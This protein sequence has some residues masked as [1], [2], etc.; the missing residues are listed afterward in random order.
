[1][2][3][4]TNSTAAAS[5]SSTVK[6]DQSSPGTTNLVQN[7]AMPD[8][9]NTFCPSADDSAAYE[10][11]SI[12][13]AS[14]GTLYGFSGYNSSG[15]D[16]FIQ[17]HNSITLPADTAVPIVIVLAPAGGSFSWDSGLFGKYFSAGITWCNSSTGLTKTIGSADCW[18]NLQYL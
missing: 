2:G 5:A 18:V 6:I 12:S 4:I 14:P 1:M 7:K 3:H 17:I 16:Q 9:T 15:S 8:S 13:K 10:A 11:S